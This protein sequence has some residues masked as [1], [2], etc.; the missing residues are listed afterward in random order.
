MTIFKNKKHMIIL[1]VVFCISL[2]LSIIYIGDNKGIMINTDNPAASSGYRYESLEELTEAADRIVIGTVLETERYTEHTPRYILNI[3]ESIKGISEDQTI[4]VF[5][6]GRLNEHSTYFLFLKSYDSPYAERPRH[7]VMHPMDNLLIQN[8]T[9]LSGSLEGYEVDVLKKDVRAAPGINIFRKKEEVINTAKNIEELVDLSDFIVVLNTEA[10]TN[11]TAD[12]RE[13]KVDVIQQFKGD[14]RILNQKNQQFPNNT[15]LNN[16]YLVFFKI[17]EGE[18]FESPGLSITT[19]IG[20][21]I[22]K[23]DIEAWEEAMNF[24]EKYSP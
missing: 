5:S 23:E 15:K 11:E 16:E 21:V 8:N 7:V 19:R 22:S 2:V 1:F 6:S 12:V 18:D 4:D 3:N 14:D 24:L 17:N 9:F 20:S 10:L 13:Y